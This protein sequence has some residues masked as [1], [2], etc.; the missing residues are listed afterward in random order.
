ML[1]I[2]C[3]VQF[4]GA[5]SLSSYKFIMLSENASS[6]VQSNLL[7]IK[8]GIRFCDAE[9]LSSYKFIMLSKK[10]SLKCTK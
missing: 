2:K 9:Y 5:E 3:G 8:C 4:C 7:R 6:N 10:R 1:R